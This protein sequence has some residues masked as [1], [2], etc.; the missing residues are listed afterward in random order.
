MRRTKHVKGNPQLRQLLVREAARLMYEDG[1]S[2][3]HDAKTLAV[4]RILS[5]G[6]KGSAPIRTRDLPSNGEISEE[7]ANL[8]QFHEGDSLNQ[9]LFEMRIIALE[10]MS[11]IAD[12]SPRLIGSVSTGRVRQNSDIDLHVF[13]DITEELF[14]H[15]SILGW[16][17]EHKNITVRRGSFFVEYLHI[18]LE[19]DFPIE[20]SVYSKQEMKIRGRSSTDGKPI[21]RISSDALLKIILEEHPDAWRKHIYGDDIPPK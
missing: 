11:Q 14:E 13:T 1:V 6:R 9:Q 2:Q 19:Q 16:Q 10:I 18:Y 4:K 15:L 3:Y 7:I 17:Y 12:F 5:R 8:A 20:L 21:I